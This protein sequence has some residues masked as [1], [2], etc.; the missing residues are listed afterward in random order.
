MEL[1]ALPFLFCIT[2]FCPTDLC[3]DGDSSFWTFI[4]LLNRNISICGLVYLCPHPPPFFQLLMAGLLFIQGWEAKNN[5][6]PAGPPLMFLCFNFGK[7]FF[8]PFLYSTFYPLTQ[9]RVYWHIGPFFF[10]FKLF[11]I[12]QNNFQGVD[13][14]T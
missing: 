13:H 7:T 3:R 5:S 4:F 12:F 14:P 6:L 11:T 2:Y 1:V 8:S 10:L 9:P